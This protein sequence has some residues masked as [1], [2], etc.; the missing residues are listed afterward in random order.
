MSS[1]ANGVMEGQPAAA[2]GRPPARASSTRMIATLGLVATISGL[3][4]VSVYEGTAERIEAN[5]QALIERALF[6]VVPD[7]AVSKRQ[8]AVDAGQLTEWQPGMKAT[9]FYAAY[10]ADGQLVGL[11]AEGAAQGYADVIRVL[12]GYDPACQCITG[13]AVL[14]SAETPGLGDKIYKDARFLANFDALDA[15]LNQEGSAL[16]NPIVTVKHG[17]KR[18]PW[19]ID[20]ISGATVSSNAIGKAL[21]DAA[22]SLLPEVRPHLRAIAAMAPT[23]PATATSVEGE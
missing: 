13:N 7:G 1:E 17:S 3:L 22:G 14:K 19:E 21:N 9:P 2:P 16:V 4:V 8:L 6:Q 11:A 20:A 10:A 15:T 18:N 23:L 5:K 12:W